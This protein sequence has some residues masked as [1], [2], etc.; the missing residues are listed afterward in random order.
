M[1]VDSQSAVLGLKRWLKPK[2]QLLNE[3]R[4]HVIGTKKTRRVYVDRGSSVLFVAHIDTVQEPK[5]FKADENRI[6]A[7]GLDDRL[8]CWLAWELSRELDADLLLTDYEET[9]QT[10]IRQHEMKDYN[11]IVEFDRAG[12][13]A[14]TYEQ[15]SDE[16]KKAL[17][18]YWPIGFGS[19]S[20][21]SEAKTSACCFNLGIGY[22]LA[23]QKS[24]YVVIKTLQDQIKKFLLFYET[25]KDTTFVQD[26]KK[27]VQRD[28]WWQ[29]DDYQNEN[30]LVER[31]EL[32]GMYGAK[33]VYNWY[34]CED[35]I[36]SM[37]YER[38][39]EDEQC[40]FWSE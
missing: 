31:C 40:R 22:E 11:W 17:A 24:S 26:E 28:D 1:K 39:L 23:H 25:W 6:Y 3:H 16:F 12:N 2:K 4:K 10:T 30:D 5:F 34:L 35:C 13:D 38:A 37:V 33:L 7:S 36:E 15:D 19:Y 32:C 29:C 21:I 14:V 8:G 27:F 18:E 9:G 20:D